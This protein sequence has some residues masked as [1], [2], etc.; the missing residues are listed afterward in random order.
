MNDLFNELANITKPVSMLQQALNQEP[1]IADCFK[2][3]ETAIQNHMSSIDLLKIEKIIS[4]ISDQHPYKQSGNRDSYSQYN[5]GWSDACD[6][7]LNA[8]KEKLYE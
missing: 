4:E 7:I 8:I 1:N 2:H 3:A 5:E 6:I